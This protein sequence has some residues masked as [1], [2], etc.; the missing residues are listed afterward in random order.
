MN[1]NPI[2]IAEN[3]VAPFPINKGAPVSH[4]VKLQDVTKKFGPFTAL[5]NLSLDVVDGEILTLLGP[6]GCGKTTL[7]RLI[8]GFESPTTGAV[9]ISG[10]DVSKRPPEDRPVN[11]VFQR[12]ALFPHLDVFDNVAFGLR[13]KKVPE[14]EVKEKVNHMLKLVQLDSMASRWIN[15]L[16]GGQAQ[17]VALARALVNR[18][19]VLLLDE[20]LAALDL[21]IRHHMLGE[22]KRI[23]NETKTTFVY[24]THDQ[25]EAMILSDRIVL[26]NKGQI[27]QIDTP[28]NMYAKPKTLFAAK[29]LGET[30]VSHATVKSVAADHS[31]IDY[32]CGEVMVHRTDLHRGQEVSIS[33][34]PE[35]MALEF[36]TTTSFG[37]Q[38]NTCVGTIQDLMFIGGRVVYTVEFEDGVTYKCQVPRPA[39]GLKFKVADKV[40]VSWPA[41]AVAVLTN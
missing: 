21:K 13:L 15:E 37:A 36:V 3:T 1:V 20:P 22:L 24:V 16:S 32:G 7:M 29:F 2:R 8:A 38:V 34:R 9:I 4:I 31:I 6:S 27:E 11:M 33:I 28:E 23:H 25:D 41:E 30:N 18:P 26:M 10:E 40:L 17:R 39:E 14:K 5:S 19:K 35:S 12:Y